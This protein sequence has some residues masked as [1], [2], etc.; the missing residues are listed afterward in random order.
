MVLR[1]GG[2]SYAIIGLV[3]DLPLTTHVLPD[4]LGHYLL[5]DT[6]VALAEIIHNILFPV[7]CVR[8]IAF[9]VCMMAKYYAY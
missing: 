5:L 3:Q 2:T 8:C 1:Y 4:E 6:Y 9:S 7:G